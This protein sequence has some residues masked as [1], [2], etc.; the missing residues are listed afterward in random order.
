MFTI[1]SHGSDVETGAAQP[2][3]SSGFRVRRHHNIE[4]PTAVFDLA[5]RILGRIL[6]SSLLIPFFLSLHVV[7]LIGLHLTIASSQARRF[8][9]REGLSSSSRL[10]PS[11]NELDISTHD[12]V[13]ALVWRSTMATRVSA[14]EI[15]KHDETTS[16]M[17]ID[18]RSQLKPT[19]PPEFLGNNA[20]GFK[21]ADSV[22][23]LIAPRSLRIAAFTIRTGVK[24]VDDSYIRNLITVLK[25][26]P[27]YGQVLLSML[28]HN[29]T[30]GLF[31]TSWAKFPYADLDFVEKFGR[32]D[33]FVFPAGGYMNGIGVILPPLPS[34]HWEIMLTLEE[35]CMA[36]FKADPVWK[37]YAQIE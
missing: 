10:T 6:A 21:V 29:N 30:T 23:N 28:E 9:C 5:F 19:Q 3:L 26:V 25:E 20:I 14:G 36:A 35:K 27:D 24:S 33:K 8:D 7:C 15:S 12:A 16:G 2:Q 31:L 32:C 1:S 17:P 22:E 37:Q 11:T 18:G 34:G 4:S 13:C